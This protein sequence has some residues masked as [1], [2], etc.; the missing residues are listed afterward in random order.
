MAMVRCPQCG[1][2]A[3]GTLCFA[4]GYTWPAAEGGA[5]PAPSP[6]LAPPIGAMPTP[7]PQKGPPLAPTPMARAPTPMPA[8]REP[9]PITGLSR[10]FPAAP[11][12][13]AAAPS[14]PPNPFAAATTNPFTQ[15]ASTGGPN[16]FRPSPSHAGPPPSG[17]NPFADAAPPP[18]PSPAQPP[19]PPRT[20][21]GEMARAAFGG[22]G[23]PRS[24]TSE[25]SRSAFP[26]I[27]PEPPPPDEIVI[28]T[29]FE[30]RLDPSALSPDIGAIAGG[31]RAG[32]PN[33][34]APGAPSAAVGAGG[35]RP[36]AFPPIASGPPRTPSRSQLGGILFDG[37]GDDGLGMAEAPT[38]EAPPPRPQVPPVDWNPPAGMRRAGAPDDGL[39]AVAATTSLG[40]DLVK[41]FNDAAGDAQ[42][43]MDGAPARDD[44]SLDGI[45]G[46]G[47]DGI[48]SIDDSA[49]GGGETESLTAPAAPVPLTVRL[50]A[51]ADRLRDEGRAEDA[52]LVSQAAASLELEY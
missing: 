39:A 21:T 40:E 29:D 28:D 13:G 51:L 22:P 6:P 27:P 37:G 43:F 48:D 25:L 20:P 23:P 45:D 36:P 12:P 46:L 44:F 11:G 5:P 32:S 2:V 3:D 41:A 42:P 14:V 15:A 30:F 50:R 8:T 47:I 38:I 10:P 34:P 19:G 18:S 7:M 16:P 4:C 9:A 49:F 31:A 35:A 26:T 52:D 33:L 17:F 1:R 24:P